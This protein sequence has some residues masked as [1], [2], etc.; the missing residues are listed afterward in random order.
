LGAGRDGPVAVCMAVVPRRR[1]QEVI[2]VAR[3]VDPDV[4]ATVQDVRETTARGRHSNPIE[5]RIAQAVG[6]R[7]KA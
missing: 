3:S 2:T 6:P 7:S 5:E 1:T 4:V